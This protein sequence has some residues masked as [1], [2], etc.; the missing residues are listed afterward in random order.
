MLTDAEE[1]ELL[2]LLDAEAQSHGLLTL[3]SCFPE[4]GPYARHLYPK[5]LEFF[6]AGA[7]PRNAC[8]MGNRTGKT[9]MACYELTCHLLG[10]YPAWWEGAAFSRLSVHGLSGKQR[11]PHAISFRQRCSAPRASGAVPLCRPTVSVI[12]T[13]RLAIWLMRSSKYR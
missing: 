12:S 4:S 3:D 10:E 9:L 1:Q 8:T 13:V 11:R 5:H 7:M 2:T 6:R